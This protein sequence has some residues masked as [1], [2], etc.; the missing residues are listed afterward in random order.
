MIV[1]VAFFIL[2]IAIMGYF[3]SKDGYDPPIN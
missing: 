3:E 2:P 1:L